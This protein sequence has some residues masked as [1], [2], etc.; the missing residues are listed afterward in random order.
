LKIIFD[1]GGLEN[2]EN[3]VTTKVSDLLNVLT[4]GF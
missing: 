3:G 1:C 2:K 4:T